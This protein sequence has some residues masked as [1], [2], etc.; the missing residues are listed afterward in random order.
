MTEHFATTRMNLKGKTT[1]KIDDEDPLYWICTTWLQE[2]HSLR[3]YESNN[4]D[5][6]RWCSYDEDGK[7]HVE[8]DSAVADMNI[9][10]SSVP[11]VVKPAVTLANL[12]DNL[13]IFQRERGEA[14]TIQYLIDELAYR[15]RPMKTK[16]SQKLLT[17]LDK[18]DVE[19]AL[20]LS[21]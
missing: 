7:E 3:G 9:P 2:D 15:I 17:Q 5:R 4:G 21:K 10:T 19:A 1:L 18:F 20:E 8:W 14:R 16:R 6:Y 12:L 13:M 11:S